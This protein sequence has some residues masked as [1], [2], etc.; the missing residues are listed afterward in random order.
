MDGEYDIEGDLGADEEDDWIHDMDGPEMG[1]EP[2]MGDEDMSMELDAELEEVLRE[3]EEGMYEEDEMA[4]EGMKYEAD[5]DSMEDSIDEIIESILAEED[6]M[7]TEGSYKTKHAKW[8][9]I[10]K[11]HIQ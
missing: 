5:H 10:C 8:K 6:E 9:K 1:M 7:S 2:E 11:K 4:S 3:L